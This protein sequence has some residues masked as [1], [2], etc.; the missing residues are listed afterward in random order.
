MKMTIEWHERRLKNMEATL[1]REKEAIQ[2]R[3]H[4]VANLQLMVDELTMKIAR[5]V[6]E[7]RDGFDD[8]R[9]KACV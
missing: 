1:N 7:G 6:R 2:M 4:Q 3:Q 5:A 8:E 9:Y